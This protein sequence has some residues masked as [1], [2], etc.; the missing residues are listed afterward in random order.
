M[1]NYCRPTYLNLH[2]Y[3]FKILVGNKYHKFLLFQIQVFVPDVIVACYCILQLCLQF[4]NCF[5]NT[6]ER[7]NQNLHIRIKLS[8]A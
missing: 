5:L 8:L 6:K 7:T 4:L 3:Q 1:Q 2:T